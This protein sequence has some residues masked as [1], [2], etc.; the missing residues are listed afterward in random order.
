M[1][2]KRPF[3]F[4]DFHGHSRRSNI[5]M[6]GNNPDESWLSTDHGSN[7][8]NQYKLLPELLEKISPSFSLKDCT[9]TITKAKEFSARITLWRQFAIERAYTMEATYCGF[10]N[11]RLSGSQVCKI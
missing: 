11:K 9:F 4:V 2:K 6:Y 10:D 8:G 1:L 3:V 7:I 5:F